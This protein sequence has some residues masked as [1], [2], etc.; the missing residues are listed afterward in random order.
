MGYQL[1]PKR[2]LKGLTVLNTASPSLSKKRKI[3]TTKNIDAKPQMSMSFSII[4]SLNLRMK[5]SLCL[6]GEIPRSLSGGGRFYLLTGTKSVTKT[7]SWPSFESAKS[8][9]FFTKPSGMP[10]V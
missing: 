5:L 4:N 3:N 1:F 7:I 10:L 6:S 2:K 9:N 8:M